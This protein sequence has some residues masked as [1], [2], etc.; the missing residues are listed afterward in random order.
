[1]DST[2]DSPIPDYKSEKLVQARMDQIANHITQMQKNVAQLQNEKAYLEANLAEMERSKEQINQHTEQINRYKEKINQRTEQIDQNKERYNQCKI[3]VQRTLNP[4]GGTVNTD[5][6]VKQA[7]TAQSSDT[8]Y[9]TNLAGD[10]SRDGSMAN[11]SFSSNELSQQPFMSLGS[12]RGSVNVDPSQQSHTGL[13]VPETAARDANPNQLMSLD[14]GNGVIDE[15]SKR[16]NTSGERLRMSHNAD[17]CGE[18]SPSSTQESMSFE[19]PELGS[20]SEGAQYDV[21]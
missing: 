17:L 10:Q 21:C 20:Q 12:R 2:K 3:G 7:L 4:E 1:M 14:Q 5:T 11:S 15:S 9:D 8:A 19:S 16:D 6:S 13:E 18:P